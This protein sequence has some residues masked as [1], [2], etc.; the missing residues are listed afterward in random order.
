M[1]TPKFWRLENREIHY[2][3]IWDAAVRE[4]AYHV[5]N[6]RFTKRLS[7]DSSI[8]GTDVRKLARDGYPASNILG[9]DLRQAFI[10][11]GFRLYQ[12]KESN[13]INFFVSDIFD[14]PITSPTTTVDFPVSEIKELAQLRNRLT[15]VYTGALF[16]LFDEPT[17][18]AI[19][20]R[21][22]FLLKRETGAVVFGRHQGL[23]K[24][25]SLADYISECVTFAL[26]EWFLNLC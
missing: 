13:V 9:C 17:Q 21:I 25:G 4:Y 10:D 5:R 2:S 16:H 22:G 6:P 12:D 1:F 3:S 20:L 19:A 7:F 11:L 23:E 14:V 15:H 26:F 24:A 18:Y 8:V